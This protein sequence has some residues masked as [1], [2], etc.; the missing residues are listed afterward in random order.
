MI[1][2]IVTTVVPTHHISH[3]I[4]YITH[5]HIAHKVFDEATTRYFDKRQLTAIPLAGVAL[6]DPCV[7]GTPCN[8]FFTLCAFGFE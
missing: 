4:I 8:F 7:K 5:K 3:I 2:D 1:Y 6:R